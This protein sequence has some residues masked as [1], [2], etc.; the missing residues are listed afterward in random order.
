MNKNLK[1]DDY[2]KQKAHPM[3]VEIQR[4]ENKTGLL[5]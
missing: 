2:L 4:I 3:N 1:V 5:S